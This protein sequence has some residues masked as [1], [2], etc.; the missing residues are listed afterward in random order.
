V[1]TLPATLHAL[2]PLHVVLQ[3]TPS[4]QCPFWHC[5]SP[6]H[7]ELSASLA[8]QLVPLQKKPSA[9]L[10]GA[11]EHDVEHAAPTQVYPVVHCDC[12][13]AGHV[14]F[15]W[16]YEASV[17]VVPTQDPARHTVVTGAT[18]HAPAPS[19]PPILHAASAPAPCGHVPC[20][21][22]PVATFVHLPGEL[23]RLHALH[24]LHAV[25]QQTP[26]AQTPCRHS[27]PVVHCAPSPLSPHE[28]PVQ[29]LPL[30]HCVEFEQVE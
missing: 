1:P 22:L 26:S 30:E 2:Q 8:T 24:P 21:S 5:A 9:Q 28:L 17:C 12:D 23:E 10:A 7:A 14:P 3:Q 29:A 16:Q 20:G 18:R 13:R 11:P 15:A 4:T 19:H 6:E 27:V 25:S